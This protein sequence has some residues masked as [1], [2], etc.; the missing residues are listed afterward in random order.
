MTPVHALDAAVQEATFAL[1]KPGSLPKWMEITAL[2]R[3][4]TPIAQVAVAA[5]YPFIAAAVEAQT[6]EAI[7]AEIRDEQVE[8]VDARLHKICAQCTN[9]QTCVLAQ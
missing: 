7:A 4:M 2:G 6:R 3:N 9:C 1:A 5:A 8:Q